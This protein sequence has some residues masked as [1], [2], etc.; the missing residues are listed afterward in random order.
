[1]R[2]PTQLDLEDYIRADEEREQ[3]A[4]E[5]GGI[6]TAE[7]GT[8]HA[9]WESEDGMCTADVSAPNLDEAERWLRATYPE[10][11]GADGFWV[12]GDGEEHPIIW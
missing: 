10:D 3:R 4:K 5:N 9:T 11:I 2:K 12:F 7:G 1:M 8:Y 6:P